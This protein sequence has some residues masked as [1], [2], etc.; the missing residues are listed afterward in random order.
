M[1][2][3]IEQPLAW[4]NRAL[5]LV[6]RWDPAMLHITGEEVAEDFARNR[7]RIA[8]GSQTPRQGRHSHHPQP[9]AARE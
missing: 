6:I 2:T 1:E 5:V 8:V 3:T 7:P 4:A 9:D